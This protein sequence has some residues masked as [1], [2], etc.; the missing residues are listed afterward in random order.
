MPK[1]YQPTR[2]QPLVS[3]VAKAKTD[4]A[5]CHGVK[6][7]STKKTVNDTKQRRSSRMLFFG[8]KG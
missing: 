3:A 1:V 6:I 8:V 5:A 4:A 2:R 7:F